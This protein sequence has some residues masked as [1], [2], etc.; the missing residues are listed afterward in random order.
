MQRTSAAFSQVRIGAFPVQLR[1]SFESSV[2]ISLLTGA[3]RSQLAPGMHKW[4]TRQYQHS[5]ESTR[6][7]RCVCALF[8]RRVSNWQQVANTHTRTHARTHTHTHTHTY[9]M[10]CTQCL[11]CKFMYIVQYVYCSTNSCTSVQLAAASTI[12]HAVIHWA[13]EGEG[14]TCISEVVPYTVTC[15]R[16]CYCYMLPYIVTVHCSM[17]TFAWEN[18]MRGVNRRANQFWLQ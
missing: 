18:T 10:C 7:M 1:V 9:S 6:L 4:R 11:V 8:A 12:A 14:A 16:T 13:D 3:R 17:Q 5:T 2:L 15:Y